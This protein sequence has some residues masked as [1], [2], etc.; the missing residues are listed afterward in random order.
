MDERLTNPPKDV[1]D[2]VKKEL[3]INLPKYIADTAMLEG[4]PLTVD[5]VGLDWK[6][7]E[8]AYEIP[9]ADRTIKVSKAWQWARSDQADFSC[10]EKDYKLYY[11]LSYDFYYGGYPGV[12][13]RVQGEQTRRPAHIAIVPNDY[14]E[15][16]SEIDLTQFRF[17][18]WEDGLGSLWKMSLLGRKIA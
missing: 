4:T 17:K 2:A 3:L 1:S 6:R 8:Y 16:N 12:V 15:N 9:I 7:N 13:I 10:K 5:L 18:T 11:R 14:L